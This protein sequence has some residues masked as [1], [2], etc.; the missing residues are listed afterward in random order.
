MIMVEVCDMV[1]VIHWRRVSREDGE[2]T[3]LWTYVR[4]FE[5]STGA[6][7]YIEAREVVKSELRLDKGFEDLSKE[8]RIYTRV[9]WM[10]GGNA[11]I[12]RI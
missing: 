3:E 6:L 11:E 9:G 8:T 12:C 10:I 7:I 1:L 5:E 2:Q 4:C